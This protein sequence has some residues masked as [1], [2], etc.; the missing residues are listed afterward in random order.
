M[1]PEQMKAGCVGLRSNNFIQ[2][3]Y[4]IGSGKH[5]C[6]IGAVGQSNG[7]KEEYTADYIEALNISTKQV[8]LLLD[9]N[10][11]E[12]LSFLQIAD[13]IESHQEFLGGV[14]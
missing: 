10:D 5:T 8:D 12:K 14:E 11:T 3:R 13:L 4:S 2:S 9:W 1:T 6:A 7:L